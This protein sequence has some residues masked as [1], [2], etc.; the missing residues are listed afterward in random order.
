MGNFLTK[1][2]DNFFSEVIIGINI[3]KNQ[4]HINVDINKASKL[5]KN[6][7]KIFFIKE[8]ALSD[9]AISFLRDL[10]NRY[11]FTYISTLINAK[12]Q[13]AIEGCDHNSLQ[14]FNIIPDDVSTICINQQWQSFA[15][16]EDIDLIHTKF[17]DIDVDYIISPFSILYYITKN[18]EFTETTLY[19]LNQK[20]NLSIA[21]FNASGLIF[22]AHT[23]LNEF[24]IDDTT[25]VS[26]NKDKE[27]V[28]DILDTPAEDEDL[29][30]EEFD[31]EFDDTI[32]EDTNTDNKDID[33]SADD[34][35]IQ[36]SED[37][38]VSGVDDSN[39][40]IQN[41]YDMKKSFEILNYIKDS[42]ADFY[43]NEL[44]ESD[45]I[46]SVVI[47]TDEK[48]SIEVCEFIEDEIMLSVEIL[49]INIPKILCAMAYDENRKYAI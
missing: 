41:E 48:L 6:I 49:N 18:I 11:N 47:A 7:D 14:K 46:G 32:I 21:I 3:D 1:I 12:N 15:Y 40:T 27:S 45:F 30:F 13:G 36:E 8:Y 22:S 35:S 9:E 38:T 29:D 33:E 2:K 26:D 31:D 39:K 28:S 16:H 37:L 4:C 20:E 34:K 5:K 44:Y 24:N 43:K 19:I 42:I 17:N 10:Y 25:E 23:L